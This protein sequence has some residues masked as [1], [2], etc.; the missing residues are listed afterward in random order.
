[1]T[2]F[3]V[4][5]NAQNKS[6]DDLL[7]LFATADRLGY[8]WVSASD[9]FPG[10]LGPMSHE[11]IALHTMIAANTTRARCGMLVYSIPFRHPIVL[12]SAVTTIDHLSGGRAAIGLGSGGAPKDFKLYGFPYPP[13]AARSEMLEEGLACITGLLRDDE[14]TFEGKHFQI[15]GARNAPRPVQ[16]R[17][18]VWVGTTGEQ[19]GLRLVAQYADGWNAGGQSV[20]SFTH[21]RAVLHEHCHRLSRDPSSVLCSVNLALGGDDRGIVPEVFQDSAL[22]GSVDEMAERIDAYV[23]AGADQVNIHV[24]LLERLGKGSESKGGP[25]PWDFARLD[26]LAR[27]F[28]LDA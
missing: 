4:H 3:G 8:G 11:A 18:P 13:I 20:E 21:K 10:S 12:A 6:L 14:V 27:V 2:I 25:Y 16:E 5:V 9:H 23:T 26:G 7:T 19:T 15:S 22:T 28:G 1:M 17:L 24:G